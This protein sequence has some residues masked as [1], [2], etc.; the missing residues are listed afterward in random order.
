[1]S[2]QEKLQHAKAKERDLKEGVRLA[3]EALQ[4]A[5]EQLLLQQGAIK[6]LEELLQSSDVNPHNNVGVVVGASS[7][8][9]RRAKRSTKR[10]LQIRK[11]A[12][13]KIL[14]ENGDS[15]ANDMLPEVNA[16]LPY[17]L[18]INHLRNV[19][20]KF[21]SDFKK[22]E[23]HGVWCLTDSART[24]FVSDSSGYSDDDES[25]SS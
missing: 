25:S 11:R 3:K 14:I 10:E 16:L 20:K 4:A 8:N 5:Q 1:M 12:A 6:M 19:L 17:D 2:L 22:G 9:S 23:D 15:T 24:N 21:T 7:V 18:E 13:H